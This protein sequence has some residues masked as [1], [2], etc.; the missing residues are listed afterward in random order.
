MPGEIIKAKNFKEAKEQLLEIYQA[1]STA[2]VEITKTDYDEI[3]ASEHE[4]SDNH[5]NEKR[6]GEDTEVI[7]L[8]FY[9]YLPNRWTAYKI[10]LRHK[11]GTTEGFYF[12]MKPDIV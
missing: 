11:N 8:A 3:N 1:K 7:D 6:L 4:D 2:L 10:I 12:K 5:L 9:K